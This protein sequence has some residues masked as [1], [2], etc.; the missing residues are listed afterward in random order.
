MEC[1][2]VNSCQELLF[3]E[4]KLFKSSHDV[5]VLPCCILIAS[6]E[7]SIC[8]IAHRVLIGDDPQQ[9]LIEELCKRK[10]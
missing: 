3:G 4:S 2:T 9:H 6:V 10:N 1:L 5:L 7:Y 8:L